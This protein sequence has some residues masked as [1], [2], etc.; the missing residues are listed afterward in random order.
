DE[1]RSMVRLQEKL[2]AHLDVIPD[3]ASPPL[4]KPHSIDDVPVLALT[5]WSERYSGYELRRVASELQEQVKQVRGVS[6]VTLTG[7]ERR[8]LRVELDLERLAARNLSPVD[9]AN[10]LRAANARSRTGALSKDNREFVLEV[11]SLLTRAGDVEAIVVG[12]AA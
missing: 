5:L 11:G 10:A 6:E 12:A 7:G 2:A 8:E 4:V 3:G 9:V 1:E